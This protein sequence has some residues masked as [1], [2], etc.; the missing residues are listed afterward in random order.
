MTKFN[1]QE[2]GQH[3][4]D[5]SKFLLQITVAGLDPFI[6][7]NI[8]HWLHL[9]S[10]LKNVEFNINGLDHTNRMVEDLYKPIYEE[11]SKKIT[12][13]VGAI[14]RFN[15]IWAGLETLIAHFFSTKGSKVEGRIDIFCNYLKTNYEPQKNLIL[16]NQNIRE[17]KRLLKQSSLFK[18][19]QF[20][21]HL[22]RR[23]GAI[24]KSGV[25]LNMV[26]NIKSYFA[27]GSCHVPVAAPGF[28]EMP[29]DSTIVDI[30]SR[31][32]LLSIQMFLLTSFYASQEKIDCW[33]Y[34]PAYRRK[35]YI[36]AFLRIVH[37]RL[38][39]GGSPYGKK[40]IWQTG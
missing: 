9:A 14:T 4:F 28:E 8:A 7:K 10:G 16:Y 2:I 13:V 30:C 12:R 35:I 6:S 40:S 23:T 37:L 33:W 34:E 31:I 22:N 29:V 18:I 11:R 27:Y 39:K 21:S 15:N 3:S 19:N 17:L 26:Q 20:R 38:I 36:H 25:G 32:V 24:G 5:L 1:L